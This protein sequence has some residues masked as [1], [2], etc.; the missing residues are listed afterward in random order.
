MNHWAICIF[1][2]STSSRQTWSSFGWPWLTSKLFYTG[3]F[4]YYPQYSRLLCSLQ[5]IFLSDESFS[6]PQEPGCSRP[7]LLL[8]GPAEVCASRSLHS[9]GNCSALS[10]LHMECL[11]TQITVRIHASPAD[12]RSL[13]LLHHHGTKP[14]LKKV[15][16]SQRLKIPPK[17]SDLVLYCVGLS[18]WSTL[19]C[20]HLH[21][22]S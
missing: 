10:S 5:C 20:T 14:Q 17:G 1:S 11:F 12:C 2:E 16:G 3:S 21:S 4:D 18:A 7:W 19:Q 22:L 13:S 15:L 8:F 6:S 9:A